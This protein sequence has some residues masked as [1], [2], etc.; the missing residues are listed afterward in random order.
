LERTG[1]AYTTLRDRLKAL[2]T[3]AKGQWVVKLEAQGEPI[4]YMV[5]TG[6]ERPWVSGVG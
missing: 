6:R 2:Q 4:R 3:P 5:D 1:L